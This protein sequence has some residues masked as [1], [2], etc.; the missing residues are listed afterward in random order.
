MGRGEGKGVDGYGVL[1]G[2]GR[3]RGGEM[4][5]GGEAGRGFCEVSCVILKYRGQIE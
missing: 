5:W 2:G 1:V 3:E 4:C